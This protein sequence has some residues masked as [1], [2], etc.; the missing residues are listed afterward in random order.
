M[1]RLH[2]AREWLIAPAPD[3]P[4]RSLFTQVFH[5]PAKATPTL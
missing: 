3:F 2:A 4:R 1:M 5:G